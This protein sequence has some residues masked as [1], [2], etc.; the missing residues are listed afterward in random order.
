MK[1]ALVV[2]LVA[3][4]TATT[5]T[6]RRDTLDSIP[7]AA[8]AALRAKAQGAAIEHVSHES[9][10]GVDVYEASWHVG[11][12]ER[13][14][15][16]TAAGELVEYEEQLASEQVPPAVRAAAEQQLGA[17]TIKFVKLL[18]GNYEAEA[19]VDGREREI[20]LGADGRAVRGDDDD[21][22]EDDDD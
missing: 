14:A 4:G 22:D 18:S 10:H 11:G 21:E 12:L 7:N 6:T 13:E 20:T 5:T 1:I 9:E 2:L 8:A 19:V 3:C 15:S 17:T 16:V